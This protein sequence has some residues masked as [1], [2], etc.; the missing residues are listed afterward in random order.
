MSRFDVAVSVNKIEDT[1]V[2]ITKFTEAEKEIENAK[3]ATCVGV[4][5][6]KDME[7]VLPLFANE[8]SIGG[9]CICYSKEKTIRIRCVNDITAEWLIQ[10]I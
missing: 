4:S 2:D 9:A 8:A 1:F 10:K 7:N 3:K 5:L 6:F